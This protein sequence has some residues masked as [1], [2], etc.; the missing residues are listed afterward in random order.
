V[1]GLL[2]SYSALLGF[3]ALQQPAQPMQEFPFAHIP[4]RPQP[5]LSGVH[6]LAAMLYKPLIGMPAP[7]PPINLPSVHPMSLG[8]AL[9][10]ANAVAAGPGQMPFAPL[11]AGAQRQ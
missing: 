2:D 10:A 5:D 1:P 11:M 4:Q 9:Q 3:P 8:A 6:A 7:L